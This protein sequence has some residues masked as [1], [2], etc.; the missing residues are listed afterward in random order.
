MVLTRYNIILPCSY[1]SNPASYPV[2]SSNSNSAIQDAVCIPSISTHYCSH[3]IFDTSSPYAARGVAISSALVVP[4]GS[5]NSSVKSP[6]TS[7]SSLRGC[8]IISATTSSMVEVSSGGIYYP[9]TCHIF[10]PV[11]IW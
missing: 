11:T 1:V 5:A 6:V 9:I 10:C 8:L 7:S 2:L 4:S 3:H